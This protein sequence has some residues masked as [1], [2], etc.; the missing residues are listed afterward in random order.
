[1]LKKTGIVKDERYLRHEMGNFHPESPA[2]LEAIYK[3]LESP[4]MKDKFVNI[5]PRH[6]THEEIEMIHSPSYI[7]MVAGTAGKSHTFLDPDTSTSP[8]SYDVARLAVGGL[9]NAIDAVASG[10]VD[11]AFAFIRPP[12]HH[13]ETGRAAGFCIFN[14]IAIGAL[15]AI[16]KHGMKRILI[17]DW[18]LHHG[19]GTQH[20]FYE[21]SRVLYFSTHQY[22][23]YP[24]TG[25]IN[26]TGK[27]E[28][29]GYTINVPLG[30]G[31][32]DAEYLKIF[33]RVLQPVALAFRPDMVMLS[34]GFDIYYGDPLGGMKVTPA[35]FANL[36]R[37]LL[38]IV[39]ECSGGKFVITLEGGY[40]IQGQSQ[41][42]RAVLNE[43]RG[44]TSQTDKNLDRIES[45]ATESVDKT[46]D[47][48]IRQIQGFWPVF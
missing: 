11:N 5:T 18:D 43:M 13:A 27:K 38:N 32:G 45:E 4:D 17:A 24:G 39:D 48:V 15:H 6:A 21:D 23:F 44:E 26:E 28:G 35:G 29:L 1:M 25:G 30:P 33:R 34:A 2:R 14:N 42:A 46:I 8:E 31:P 37:V 16:K 3:M 7:E 9:L 41:S 12:G 40:D 36:A 10:S 19:N 22:P 20:S 47:S